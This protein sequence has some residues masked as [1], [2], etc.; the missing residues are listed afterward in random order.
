MTLEL[1]ATAIGPKEPE[2]LARDQP[3]QHST[4]PLDRRR[5][6]RYATNDPVEIRVLDAGGGPQFSGRV[7]D[8]SRSGLRIEI[9]TQVS[10]GARLEV[11]LPDGATIFGEA[12]YCRRLPTHYHVGLAIEV[13]AYTQPLLTN[14]MRDTELSLYISGKG[15]SA[16]EAIHVKNHLLTCTNCQERLT[17]KRTLPA[18]ASGQSQ[19]LRRRE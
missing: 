5:E 4:P 3:S 15:L 1:K 6:T 16:L 11:I 19:K 7:L 18:P 2:E 8:V 12:R 9:P 14:H 10:K 17:N 13:V